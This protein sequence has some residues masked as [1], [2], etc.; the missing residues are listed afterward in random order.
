M[1]DHYRVQWRYRN[2]DPMLFNYW[3]DFGIYEAGARTIELNFNQVRDVVPILLA[4]K[5]IEFH[6]LRVT[7][8]IVD[9]R[10]FL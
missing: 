9:Y 1:D 6:I 2:P 8:D 5:L 10:S 3:R 7:Y 4:D